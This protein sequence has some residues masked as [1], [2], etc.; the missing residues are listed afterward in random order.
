MF[1]DGKEGKPPEAAKAGTAATGAAPADD[2]TRAVTPTS[3]YPG[4]M[5]PAALLTLAPTLLLLV[6]FG[7]ALAVLGGLATV[8]FPDTK[9]LLEVSFQG[10]FYL[11]PIIYMPAVMK[12]RLIGQYL[13]YNPLTSFL[14]LLRE[15]I[16][17]GRIPTLATFGSAATTTLLVTVLAVYSLSRLEKRFIYYL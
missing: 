12:T 17:E 8:H 7:W 14:L 10:L 5:N 13:N 9:H 6:V 16:M 4:P 3:E 1:A 2:S 15:P 11:T